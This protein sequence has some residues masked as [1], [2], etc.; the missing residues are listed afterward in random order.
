MKRLLLIAA[1]VVVLTAGGTLAALRAVGRDAGTRYEIVFDN[2]FGLVEGA[3]F[4]V[5]GVAVGSI[6]EL[7]VNLA[8]SR[9]LITVEVAD[10]G[11]GGLTRAARCAIEPQSLIGAYFGICQPDDAAAKLTSVVTHTL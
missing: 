2:A 9:A 3:D 4:K 5:G 8:D 10:P 6:S 7:D 1:A 11:F